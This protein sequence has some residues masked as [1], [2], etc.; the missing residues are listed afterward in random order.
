MGLGERIRQKP[1]ELSVHLCLSLF[2]SHSPYLCS[3]ILNQA[4]SS[5]AACADGAGLDCKQQAGNSC[6]QYSGCTQTGDTKPLLQY[7]R[8]QKLLIQQRIKLKCHLSTF[9]VLTDVFT[10]LGG[11]TEPCCGLCVCRL[12]GEEAAQ[13]EGVRR[14]GVFRHYPH[15]VCT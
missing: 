15:P 1:V 11:E 10:P 4:V 13:G 2:P 7:L 12:F 5:T 8:M 3:L 6:I 14:D 9:I